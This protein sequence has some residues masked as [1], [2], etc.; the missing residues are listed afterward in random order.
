MIQSRAEKMLSELPS[1]VSRESKARKLQRLPSSDFFFLVAEKER[2]DREEMERLLES[3]ATERY[4]AMRSGIERRAKLL[5][6]LIENRLR[7]VLVL[8]LFDQA[9]VAGIVD[10]DNS[11]TQEEEKIRIRTRALVLE[12]LNDM[13]VS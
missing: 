4:A 5:K 2:A 10:S 12:F 3:G 9:S 1:L 7:K 11:L 8:A 13:G 6:D